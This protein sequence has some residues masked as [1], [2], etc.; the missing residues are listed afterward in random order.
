MSMIK[1]LKNNEEIVK[2]IVEDLEDFEEDTTVTYEVW[3]IGFDAD[4]EINGTDML[5]KSFSDP[6]EA[7]KY[8]SNLTLADIIYQAAEE[9][10]GKEPTTTTAYITIEVETVVGDEDDDAMNVGTI[11]TKDFC[12]GEAGPNDEYADVVELTSNDYELL[13]D[14]SIKVSRELLG[15]F[16]KNDNVQFMYV[17]EDN[18]PI[19]TYKIISKTTENCYICE[20]IY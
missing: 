3:A 10:N 13:E 8:A 17:D 7:V 16:N 20:F 11:F 6:D 2:C 12:F 19:M 5:V 4:G 14:G 15:N 9:D 1:D 18:K